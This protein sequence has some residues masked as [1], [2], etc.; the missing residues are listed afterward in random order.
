MS[1]PSFSVPFAEDHLGNEMLS[2][3]PS[4]GTGGINVQSVGWLLSAISFF[5]PDVRRIMF[6]R[7]YNKLE[8][9]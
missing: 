8:T 6:S 3:S 9:I 5:V 7:I 1:R 2:K 4:E